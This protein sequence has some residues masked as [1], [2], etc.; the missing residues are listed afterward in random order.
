MPISCVRSVTAIVIV[1]KM[2]IAEIKTAMTP[3]KVARF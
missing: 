2:P 3:T 1:L